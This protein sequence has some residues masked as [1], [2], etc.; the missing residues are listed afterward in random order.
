[1]PGVVYTE[2]FLCIEHFIEIDRVYRMQLGRQL[3]D[4]TLFGLD[5]RR[6]HDFAPSL[7]LAFKVGLEFLRRASRNVEREIGK[8]GAYVRRVHR[9]YDRFMESP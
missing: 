7:Q 2:I 3:R 1:M 8:P 4:V 5:S 6:F 9:I